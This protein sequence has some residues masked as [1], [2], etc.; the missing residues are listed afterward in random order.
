MSKCITTIEPSGFWECLEELE[1][2]IANMPN[3]TKET[4]DIQKCFEQ[5]FECLKQLGISK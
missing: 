3:S 1:K 4:S 2:L 5:T